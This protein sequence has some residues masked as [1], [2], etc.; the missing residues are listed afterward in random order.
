MRWW[1]RDRD[2]YYGDDYCLFLNRVVI[3]SNHQ[4][5]IDIASIYNL[6]ECEENEIL[7]YDPIILPLFYILISSLLFII[8]LSH[9]H[10]YLFII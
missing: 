1:M 7:F 10:I 6:G 9:Q 3:V 5:M 2:I 8:S 4:S